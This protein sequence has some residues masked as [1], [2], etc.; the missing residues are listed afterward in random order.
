MEPKLI[1]NSNYTTF[2]AYYVQKENCL[3]KYTS[4]C[5]LFLDIAIVL[6][7]RMKIYIFKYN[8]MIKL[9]NRQ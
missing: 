3:N 8:F 5:S 4:H 6:K 1:S 2:A 9:M 7:F